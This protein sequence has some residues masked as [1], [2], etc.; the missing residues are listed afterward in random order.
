MAAQFVLT[1]GGEITVS[2]EA[3]ARLLSAGSGD[4]ALLYLYILSHGG[5]YEPV[6]AAGAIH[7][8]PEQVENAMEALEKLGEGFSYTQYEASV[9]AL[10]KAGLMSR[11]VSHYT[12]NGTYLRPRKG[13]G[14]VPV[15]GPVQSQVYRVERV[16]Y[17]D[18][19]S[20]KGFVTQRDP[21]Q[22]RECM[23]D[24]RRRWRRLGKEYA[25]AVED[26]RENYR[27]LTGWEFWEKYLG[28]E[29]GNPG[30][31]G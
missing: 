2:R 26:Y 31:K 15:A 19:E 29:K 17:Y 21:R 16:V 27:R 11:I 24:L 28:L 25:G 12:V 10:P 1:E 7:R 23:R 8:S 30:Q 5:H 4:A 22:A 13:Y 9:K 14:I 6:D 3:T 20:G 18:P